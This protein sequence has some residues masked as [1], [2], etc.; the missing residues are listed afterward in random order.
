MCSCALCS[1]IFIYMFRTQREERIKLKMCTNLH[2]NL[3]SSNLQSE[4]RNNQRLKC[5][6][7]SKQ[8][9]CIVHCFVCNEQSLSKTVRC[10]RSVLFSI[11]C[12]VFGVFGFWI[13]TRC[14]CCRLFVVFYRFKFSSFSR[15]NIHAHPDTF[16]DFFFQHIFRV[17]LCL[18]VGFRC[19][20]C[21]CFGFG[22][23]FID[24]IIKTALHALVCAHAQT[25]HCTHLSAQ[26]S[27]S[28]K[29]LFY[30]FIFICVAFWICGAINTQQQNST[31]TFSIK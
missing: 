3:L 8:S 16:V 9:C 5:I 4:I 19:Y 10:V 7:T 15:K 28:V 30:L 11:N 21:S 24:A 2:S 22:F 17:R 26:C 29:F 1:S 20:S 12:T 23:F 18:S 14:V 25:I 13:R 6:P 27:S 31:A